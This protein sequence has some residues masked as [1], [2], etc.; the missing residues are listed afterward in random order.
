MLG[1]LTSE[2]LQPVYKNLCGWLGTRRMIGDGVILKPVDMQF[3]Q[4]LMGP[5]RKPVRHQML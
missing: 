3:S 4:P 1:R 5:R 2:P